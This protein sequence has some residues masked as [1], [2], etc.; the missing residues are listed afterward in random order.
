[1]Y[2]CKFSK[3][4][5]YLYVMW[6]VSIY[7]R[8]RL[9]NMWIVSTSEHIKECNQICNETLLIVAECKRNCVISY[10]QYIELKLGFLCDVG[11]HRKP[12]ITENK[13]N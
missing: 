12:Q 5:M 9:L 4:L 10:I 7:G 2:I 6:N 3:K 11:I 8:R 13:R 1:M